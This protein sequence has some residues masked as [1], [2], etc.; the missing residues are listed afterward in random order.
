MFS[1]VESKFCPTFLPVTNIV[2]GRN[3]M[4]DNFSSKVL[5]FQCFQLTDI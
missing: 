4:L 5:L 3:E 1:L 2:F